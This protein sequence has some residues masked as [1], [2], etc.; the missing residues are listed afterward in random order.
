[1]A[2]TAPLLLV[3]PY[4]VLNNI[5]AYHS[6]FCHLKARQKVSKTGIFDPLPS[7][8]MPPPPQAPQ[9]ISL[10]RDRMGL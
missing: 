6:C 2:R 10:R 4:P 3:L 9:N 5:L 1:M 8:L 7:L